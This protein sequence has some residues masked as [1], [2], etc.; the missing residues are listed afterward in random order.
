[1]ATESHEASEHTHI[2]KG[3]RD[4]RGI[5]EQGKDSGCCVARLQE[6]SG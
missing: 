3:G 5:G 2:Q 4:R 6:Y 1:M